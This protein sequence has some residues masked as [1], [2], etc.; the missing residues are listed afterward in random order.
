MTPLNGISTRS[1]GV[2][3][4]LQSL[5]VGG[6]LAVVDA[7]LQIEIVEQ[8]ILAGVIVEGGTA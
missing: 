4:M 2:A 3:E 1:I 8:K 7:L 6:N 5:G